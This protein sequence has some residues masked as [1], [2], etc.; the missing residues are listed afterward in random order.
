MVR[1]A[2]H[3]ARRVKLNVYRIM[4]GKVKGKKLFGTHRYEGEENIEMDLNEI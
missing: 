4:V 3:V 1:M 2:E